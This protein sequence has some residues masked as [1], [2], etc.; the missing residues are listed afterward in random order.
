ME[1]PAICCADRS[2][3]PIDLG[4]VGISG[5]MRAVQRAVDVA[6]TWILVLRFTEPCQI[7]RR[8]QKSWGG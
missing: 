2:G 3:E 8:C 5:V 4:R 1:A 7:S 6:A